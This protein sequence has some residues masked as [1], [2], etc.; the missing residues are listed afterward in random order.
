MTKKAQKKYIKDLRIALKNP[1]N[2]NKT[3]NPLYI[4]QYINEE[5]K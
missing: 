4:K 3:K 1:K 2:K 5:Y